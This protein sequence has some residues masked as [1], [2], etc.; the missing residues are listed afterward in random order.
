MLAADRGIISATKSGLLTYHRFPL[1]HDEEAGPSNPSRP[2]TRQVDA[3][4]LTVASPSSSSRIFAYAGKEVDVTICD[5]ERTF[6]S[7]SSTSSSVDR[8]GSKRKK[9]ELEEGEIWRAKNVR[10]IYTFQK[11]P[12]QL[13]TERHADATKFPSTPSTCPSSLYDL[14][15][16]HICFFI[17]FQS[18]H[19]CF[20]RSSKW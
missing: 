1:H 7:I 6:T 17:Q 4:L 13:I 12:V 15:H 20:S 18:D 14:P 8:V 3:P 9:K 10:L 16:L 19:S 11:N 2:L 5:V